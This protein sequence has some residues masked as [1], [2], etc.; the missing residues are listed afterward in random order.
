VSVAFFDLDKTLI[1]RNSAVLWIFRQWRE[2]KEG[3]LAHIGGLKVLNWLMR[4]SLGW[5]GAGVVALEEAM[6]GFAGI[7]QVEILEQTR[8][9]YEEEIRCLYRPGGMEELKRQRQAGCLCILL[10]ST[11]QYLGELVARDLGL[12]GCLANALEVDVEGRLTG[13]VE[14]IVC[15]G[16]GKLL[17]AQDKLAQLNEAME[18]CSFYT[19]S[20]AD[21]PVMEAVGN[22]VAV[23]A[24]I[25][26]RWWARRGGHP[27]VDWGT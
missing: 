18:A 21:L 8:R 17:K 16:R 19:D 4:Y 13:R 25:R 7:S 22:P 2:G 11:T 10:S 9:F 26:L 14:G 23:N 20:Y 1:S 5:G 15:Y 27:V 3:P 12:D 24:D 6:G